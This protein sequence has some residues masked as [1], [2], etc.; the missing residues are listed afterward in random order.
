MGAAG[1]LLL[2]ATSLP[3]LALVETEIA[4]QDF[5]GST[6]DTWGYTIFPGAGLI[7]TT[8]SRSYRG[9]RSLRLQGSNRQNADPYVVFSNIPLSGISHVRLSIAFSA[10]GPDSGD[11]LYLELSYNGGATWNGAGSIKLV[12]GF[13]NA[14]IPFG[15]T[16]AS[17][18]TTVATNPWVV[19]LPEAA[20]QVMVRVRFDEVS[21][22][23]ASIDNYFI[24]HVRLYYIPPGQPPV[25][26]EL[27]NRTAAVGQVLTFA[28]TADDLDGDLITLSSSNLPAGALFPTASETGMVSQNFVFAPP[29][30]LA[31]QVV[32]TRFSAT[33]AQGT[34]LREAAIEVVDRLVN[35]ENTRRLVEESDA[36]FTVDVSISRA[37]DATVHVS[38]SGEAVLNQDFTLSST[39]LVFAADGT[40]TQAVTVTLINDPLPEGLERFALTL[41]QPDQCVVGPTNRHEVALRD[42]DS[43]TIASANLTSGGG[44]YYREPGGRILESLRPD[45]VAIQEFN[46]TNAL[47]H[48]D[49]VD[50]HFGT[51]FNFYVESNT[52]PNGIISRWPIVEAG[53]WPD[54]VVNGR[55]FAWATIDLPGP[56]KLHVV[57]VHLYSSGTAADRAEEARYL[58]NYLHQAGFDPDD[59][60]AVCGDLNTLTRTEAALL[61]LT[62]VVSDGTQPKDQEGVRET[63]RNRNRPF[64]YILPNAPLEDRTAALTVGGLVFSNGLV[65]DTRLWTN[66]ALPYPAETGDS[67]A[68]FMAH[69]LVMKLFALDPLLTITTL[70]GPHGALA[71]HN[72]AVYAGSSVTFT[73]APD[74]YFHVDKISTNTTLL[75]G[76]FDAGPHVFTWSNV[77]HPGVVEV[78]FAPNLAT[79]GVPEWWLAQF[80]WTNLFD[81]AAL[82]DAD[83]DGHRTWEEY[84]AGTHPLDPESVLAIVDVRPEP[85]VA[86]VVRWLS[87][88]NRFYTVYRA[89]NLLAGFEPVAVRLPATPP[90]NTYTDQVV[91]A[92]FLIYRVD[93]AP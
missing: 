38:A 22:S 54:P 4:L 57:S 90:L 12:D 63:N 51:G 39:T 92:E 70:A 14:E 42:D 23:N 7:S 29:P 88:S 53:F 87:A 25:F 34:T 33:D 32:T 77:T 40:R 8:T 71:P 81:D 19:F 74:A 52:L 91:D 5:E 37:V 13:N 59:Y 17:D 69:M 46:V 44:F 76:A 86:P 50:R 62:N 55:D 30:E 24:D 2:V 89:T 56:R 11:D 36:P 43:V 68:D 85:G 79:H 73:A 3:A 21:T 58:T 10:S 49:F 93:A 41:T 78:Q 35:F 20:T 64:D 47:G 83:E 48:R 1:F 45:V 18:P 82:D 66:A 9:D 28:V 27:E 67:G 75:A 31:G 65:F 72:P 26:R 84:A 15:E 80:G 16:R 60:L 61:V 6:N